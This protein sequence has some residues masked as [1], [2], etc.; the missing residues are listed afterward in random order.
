MTKYSIETK[1]KLINLTE[2]ENYSIRS[3]AK[4][5]M[6]VWLNGFA[7]NIRSESTDGGLN[8]GWVVLLREIGDCLHTGS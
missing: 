2:I 1:K 5:L 6:D 3:A 8:T 4:E 7:E